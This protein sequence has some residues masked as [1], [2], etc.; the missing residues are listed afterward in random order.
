MA[1]NK[2]S[3]SSA[4]IRAQSG[5]RSFILPDIGFKKSPE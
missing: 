5:E 1:E 3:P 2:F 4:Q